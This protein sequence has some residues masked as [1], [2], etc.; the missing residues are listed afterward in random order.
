LKQQSGRQTVFR[1]VEISNTLKLLLEGRLDYQRLLLVLRL[2]A[3]LVALFL[4]II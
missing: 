4:E 2:A 3:L 1:F